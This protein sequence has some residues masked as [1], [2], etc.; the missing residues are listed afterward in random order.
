MPI[1]ILFHGD[2]HKNPG[3]TSVTETV[4]GIDLVEQQIKVARGEKLAFKQSDIKMKGWA[5]ECRINSEDVQ[6]GFVP[7][8]KNRKTEYPSSKHVRIDSGVTE[9]TTITT[10]FRLYDL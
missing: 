4:T 6:S 9:G 10:G 8:P 1:K 3:R 7:S 2:E 5:I